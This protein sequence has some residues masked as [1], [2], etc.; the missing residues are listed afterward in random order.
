MP[1]TSQAALFNDLDDFQP[2]R[3]TTPLVSQSI[4]SSKRVRSYTNGFGFVPRR[5][6]RTKVSRPFKSSLNTAAIASQG[7]RV[8]EEDSYSDGHTTL[9]SP[10]TT[11]QGGNA[12]WQSLYDVARKNSSRTEPPVSR[13]PRD[14][15]SSISLTLENSGSVARDHLASERTFL[16]YVRTSLALASSGVALVQLFTVASANSYSPPGNRLDAYIRPLGAVTIVM[17]LIVLMIGVARYFSIQAAMTKGN[18][19][20]ARIVTAAISLALTVLIMMT[21]C[22][23]V[24]GKLEPK[25]GRLQLP[26]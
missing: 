12:A 1:S 25:G 8:D 17:G 16:A 11:L 9:V 19:P 26:F 24:A 4:S 15:I 2:L 5:R 3:E 20:V 14:L 21:F 13:L 23:L 10:T 22:I 18:F 6:P 7:G